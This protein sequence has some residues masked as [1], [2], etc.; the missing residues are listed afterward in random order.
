M[1]YFLL[2]W[3][4]QPNHSPP[5]PPRCA[6]PEGAR[7]WSSLPPN[8]VAAAAGGA[9]L[10]A[11]AM[12]FYVLFMEGVPDFQHTQFKPPTEHFATK[13]VHPRPVA[14]LHFVEGV[15][16]GEGRTLGEKDAPNYM[17]E[18]TDFFCPHCQEA[19]K[20]TM[21]P[22]LAHYVQSGELRVESHPVAFLDDDSLRAAHAALCAQE[23]HKYWEVREL[24]FQVDVAQNDPD[25]PTD[26]AF[27]AALLKRIAFLAGLDL[28]SF[29]DCFRSGRHTAEVARVSQTAR[30]L[31]V[32]GTP[33]F[34]VD[35]KRHE[36]V[37]SEHDLEVALG[38]MLP[39][40][41]HPHVAAKLRGLDDEKHA[42]YHR[43]LSRHRLP[44]HHQ[45]QADVLHAQR[46]YSRGRH[47]TGAHWDHTTAQGD[48]HTDVEED[49]SDRDLDGEHTIDSWREAQFKP[50]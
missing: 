21:A 38:H 36:G 46:L 2:G 20:I 34:I 1:P 16:H 40:E 23:Q 39:E 44:E 37:L 28:G 7:A 12:P 18:F 33:F 50:R 26:T 8:A 30:D 25:D 4:K 22:I 6:A 48:W 27:T 47:H 32:H 11:C 15:L 42:A 45:E 24:L 19:H 43:A 14:G 10:C 31:G 13:A 5:L 35:G 29:V 17:V 49:D 41:D 3:C 9:V